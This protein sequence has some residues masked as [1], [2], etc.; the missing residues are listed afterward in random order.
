[1]FP[2]ARDMNGDFTRESQQL[3]S[4]I[5]NIN[6]NGFACLRCFRSFLRFVW[7]L[8]FL[9]LSLCFPVDGASDG[10]PKDE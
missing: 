8:C 1:M 10:T 5:Y 6:N 9:H 3:S 2:A 4:L 7:S